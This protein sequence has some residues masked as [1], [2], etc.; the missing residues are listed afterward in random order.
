MEET[1]ERLA[2]IVEQYVP[3]IM[4]TQGEFDAFMCGIN[5]EQQQLLA[6]LDAAVL[7]YQ[8]FISETWLKIYDLKKKMEEARLAH[9]GN[10]QLRKEINRTCH[11]IKHEVIILNPKR[12]G[13]P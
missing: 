7:E 9:V 1:R 11:N 10:E 4:E 13:Q 12:G 3:H 8:R 6:P 5:I 2:H